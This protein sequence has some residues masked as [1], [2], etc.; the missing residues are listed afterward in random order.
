MPVAIKVSP[1]GPIQPRTAERL[2]QEGFAQVAS[3][4]NLLSG[5]IR[6]IK[7]LLPIDGTAG[8]LDNLAVYRAEYGVDETWRG[9]TVDVDVAVIPLPTDVEYRY[10]WTGDGPAKWAAFTDFDTVASDL[11]LGIPVP[12]TAPGLVVTGGSGATTSRLY[13]YT[14]FSQN[15]EESGPSPANS[16]LSGF[17]DGS[18]D[19]SLMDVAPLNTGSI[20]ATAAD[21]PTAGLVQVTTSASHWLRAGDQITISGMVTMTDLDGTWVV[22]TVISATV[23]TVVLVTAQ[24]SGTGTWARVANWNTVGMTKRIYRS[25]GTVAT[26]QLVVDNIAIGDT[27]YSDTILDADILGDEL[28]SDGWLPPPPNLFAI[29]ALPN[30]SLVGLSGTLLCFSEP[31]QAHAW[32]VAFQFGVGFQTV[33]LA[34]FGTTTVVGTLGKP[35]IADGVEPASVTLQAFDSVWPCLSKRSMVSVGDGVIYA[36]LHGLAYIGTAGAKIWSQPYFTR[37]EWRDLNPASMISAA[38]EAK[39][40]VMYQSI[41][42]VDTHVLLFVPEEPIA[43]LTTLDIAAVELYADPRN[44]FLYVVD[45]EAVKQYD[46]GIGNR[47]PYQ[48][49]SK[50]YELPTPVNL[51]AARVEFVSEMTAADIVAAQATYDA[52]VATQLNKVDDGQGAIDG[53]RG[54]ASF[55]GLGSL[56]GGAINGFTPALPSLL[57]PAYVNF[58]LYSKGVIVFSVLL[59]DSLEFRLPA[60]YTS[61]AYSF[62]LN[63]TVRVKNIKV[64]ETM[65][66]LAAI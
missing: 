10:V 48:W 29:S 40:F 25:A 13:V 31:Y 44:G 28:I 24:A 64:A 2:L 32:P 14:F 12:V 55:N 7:Q 50:Q 36:T 45:N 30:G 59:Y 17:I 38:T 42:E 37:E 35:Y 34:T 1:F 66:G 27:T 58:T 19:L 33:S 20:S 16:L 53:G 51:G 9:W 5:E 8:L 11:T 49:R 15:G 22:N 63:G 6:P 23:F 4:V 62:E 26:Y 18:W 61:D 21:T 46:A 43:A 47:L 41:G 65:R 56:N 39:V 3:N 60:G 52:A 54:V 57:D